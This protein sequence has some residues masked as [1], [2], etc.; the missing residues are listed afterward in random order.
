MPN[1]STLS[2][3]LLDYMDDLGYNVLQGSNVYNYAVALGESF[4]SDNDTYSKELKNAF[5]W[6][7]ETDY[8]DDHAKDF[9]TDY[10]PAQKAYCTVTVDVILDPVGANEQ[11]KYTLV[12]GTEITSD[13]TKTKVYTAKD[14]IFLKDGSFNLNCDVETAGVAYNLNIENHITKFTT[15]PTGVTI[16]ITGSST[17]IGG[18]DIE[19][20]D[21]I[22]A[23]MLSY[24]QRITSNSNQEIYKIWAEMISGVD[25]ANF[26]WK[27]DSIVLKGTILS[28]SNEITDLSTVIDI[29][30]GDSIISDYVPENTFV[31]SIDY[32]NK[33]VT[34]N[35]QGI[36]DGAD[37]DFIFKHRHTEYEVFIY[38][39]DNNSEPLN[40]YGLEKVSNFIEIMK[41]FFITINIVD[42]IP[43]NVDVKMNLAQNKDSLK[44][45]SEVYLEIQ[46]AITNTFKS[47]L[48]SSFNDTYS[49]R[50]GALLCTLMQIEDV[51]YV[52]EVLWQNDNNLPAGYNVDDINLGISQY[53]ELRK[54]EIN[55]I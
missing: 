7:C 53:A 55:F 9:E 47:S 54:L 6:S 35:T 45:Q 27:T 39:W 23:R 1:L 21:E 16:S 32:G 42:P 30:I 33:S 43:V 28:G 25:I 52:S 8:L 14:Y 41:E 4:G 18:T 19:S 20:F 38:V 51:N 5:I 2:Q 46:E 26:R 24:N 22:R 50:Y 37:I 34:M 40:T 44:S 49:V 29:Q 3:S 12:K 13:D 10:I 31:I 15:E 17:I 36:I 48:Q 11:Q